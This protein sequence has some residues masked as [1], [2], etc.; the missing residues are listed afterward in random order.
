MCSGIHVPG[1]HYHARANPCLEPPSHSS[2][3]LHPQWSS[4]LTGLFVS[5][6][7]NTYNF[8]LFN[9]Q[10]LKNKYVSVYRAK[11]LVQ[12][13]FLRALFEKKKKRVSSS[14]LLSQ[15]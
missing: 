10:P 4:D 8:F 9:S 2:E 3:L 14:S 5:T 13:L 7:L 1:Y 11:S 6:C 15:D 12:K